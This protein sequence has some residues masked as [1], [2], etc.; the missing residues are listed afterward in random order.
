MTV[1]ITGGRAG[2]TLP[3]LMSGI[4]QQYQAGGRV[5]VLVPEQYTLQAE[6]EIMQALQLP[7]M[8]DLD[9]LS[10]TK[11]RRLIAERG[12]RPTC[13]PLD[14]RGRSMAISQALV[15]CKDDLV[16]YRRVAASV[17][18]PE[19]LASLIA[20]FEDAGLTPDTLWEGADAS[21]SAA[22]AAK[23]RDVCT[24]WRAYQQLV[25]GRFTDTAMQQQDCID[26]LQQSG[27]VTGA[28]LWVYGFDMLQL[29]MCRLLVRAAQL[30]QSMHVLMTMDSADAPDGRLF[31]P[32]RR[33]IA[34]LMTLLKE[35]GVD[36]AVRYSS[37]APAERHPALRHLE[38]SLFARSNDAFTGAQ[39]AI[40]IHAAAT[41]FAEAD[42]A[43]Q[44]LRAWHSAG[45][46]WSR[47]AVALALEPSA[48]LSMTLKA[49]GIPHYITR[50]DSVLRHGL[51]RMLT[52][53]LRAA[54]NGWQQEDV[55]EFARSGFSPLADEERCLLENYALEN[56]ITRRKWLA[57]LTRG[58]LAETIEP[59]RLRLITP[60][61]ALH[62][63]L[64][65]ART[66]A[67]SLTAIWLLLEDVG[68]YDTLLKR[69][70]DLLARGMAAEASQSRQVWQLTLDLL[71]QLHALLGESRAALRDIARFITAGLTGASVA[72][73][74]PEPDTVVIGEAG[75]LMPGSLDALL[76]MGMQDGAMASSASSLLSEMERD[77][78]SNALS[79]HIALTPT[80]Q[81][82]MRTSD[83]YR[84]LALPRK[85][86]AISF[87]EGTQDGQSL[88]P[89]GLI[90][91][92]RRIFPDI[93]IT[94]GVT[95]KAGEQ[96]LAPLPALEALAVQLRAMADGK[97]DFLAPAWQSALRWLWHSDDYAARTQQ[98]VR[99]LNARITT[100]AL[101][102][103][104]AAKLFGQDSVSISRLEEFAACPFRHFVD[105]GLKPVVRRPFEFAADEKG[106]F[107]HQALSDYATLAA[108]TPDWPNI[109]DET[110]DAL[111]DRVL[112]PLTE[113][114]DG[115]PLR[116][117]ALAQH[118]GQ[119]YLRTVRRAA[120]MFTSHARNSRFVPWASEISFGMDETGLPPVVLALHDGRRVALRGVID[121]I[122][123]FE[124]D[125]GL[126][127]RVI[128]YKSSRHA[129]DP[130]RMW[131]GL[132][133]QLLLYLRAATQ[134]VKD[135]QPAGAFYFT[136]RDPMIESADDVK[137]TAE[138][139][140][141]Q[142]LQLK[143]VVLA[144]A[145]VV[146]A[147]DSDVPGYSIGKV[148]NGDGSV[149]TYANALDLDQMEDLLTH[150]ED[151]AA[152]LA[153]RVRAGEIAVS[154]ASTGQWTACTFCDFVSVCRRD[155]SLRGCEFRELE[156]LDRK[157]LQEKLQE[158]YHS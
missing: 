40:T 46:P 82:A 48:S 14:N 109:P 58:P 118:L 88:R 155:G 87:S 121:R 130:V 16:Y 69:E 39:D 90:N 146:S 116:E 114:W 117:D 135:S 97:Q 73:L 5:I 136:V 91:D 68:A 98:M 36:A 76:V 65:S 152:Q 137:E 54:T 43:A 81:T 86:L 141:A 19:K 85:H 101:D 35:S 24:V 103:K 10:P 17:N 148:F 32:Q 34:Q 12:G 100:E 41:P 74:P 133:L 11:L 56:G 18:L 77:A 139:A 2:C 30:A 63:R 129:P 31:L 132:Q 1:Q 22:S 47:M 94:G 67:E 107:F 95:A 147:M 15:T 79:A 29:P 72:S 13:P 84:T 78:L 106:T 25:D 113:D 151:T 104:Q 23:L 150:A 20:D 145:E 108:A 127:L 111:M 153:D 112:A 140:I 142:A 134:G 157:A 158:K 38:R 51:C 120:K 64:V 37:A 3:V 138:R 42:H 75:H 125:S 102:R 144:D 4:Q 52:A 71:D 119:S 105:Y 33:C 99:S 110:I 80:E 57:P 66:A 55:L 49:A 8:L 124:G 60:L 9:V 143:G 122:D 126:Y 92:L 89:A 115:G 7:G 6:R 154:P 53:A 156:K 83:F 44:T 21:A 128:D 123:R 70:E 28:H 45:I 131:Y 59:F 61:T 96:P 27:V 50:K 93:H 149:Y 62:D 26:R